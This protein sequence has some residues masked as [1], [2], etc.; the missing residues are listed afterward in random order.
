MPLKT[1]D[2]KEEASV[3]IIIAYIFGLFIIIVFMVLIIMIVIY[4]KRI[5]DN[6]NKSYIYFVK[7]TAEQ[8]ASS[9]TAANIQTAV[10]NA[11]S[12]LV[13][14]MPEFNK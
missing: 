10:M 4:C 13:A 12:P 8:R 11:I 5:V 14:A 1:K 9:L 6:T 7:T 3:V 2:D